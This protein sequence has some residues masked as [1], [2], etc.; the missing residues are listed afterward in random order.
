MLYKVDNGWVCVG[1]INNN[2]EHLT[3][4]S[5]P[6]IKLSDLEINELR[7]NDYY[8]LKV[9]VTDFVKPKNNWIVYPYVMYLTKDYKFSSVL[10]AIEIPHSNVI[11]LSEDS[12]PITIHQKNASIGFGCGDC[13]DTFFAYGSTDKNR[14]G[15]Y[16][17]FS[18]SGSGFIYIKT[19][20]LNS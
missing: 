19:S 20:K 13:G 8:N 9:I 16:Q 4:H 10:N 3:S 6:G 11:S 2:R 12:D 17:S 5:V 7:S 15:L 18:G 14:N 1:V